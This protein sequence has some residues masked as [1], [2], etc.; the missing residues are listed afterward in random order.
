MKLYN[1]VGLGTFP[2]AGPFGSINEEDSSN[3]LKTYLKG[4]GKYLDVAPT[5][6]FGKVESFLGKELNDIER[7]KF[8]V[9][10]SCG[11]IRNGDGF[12]VSG[13]YQDVIDDCEASLKRLGLNYIDLYISHI[14]DSK[15]PFSETMSAL[16]KL[17]N[18]G[19]IKK[20]GVSNV[21]LEQLQEYNQEGEIEFVQNRFSLLNQAYSNEFIEYITENNIGL[22]AYQAI[23]RGLLTDKMLKD[24]KIDSSDLRAKKP[25]FEK[26][27]VKEISLWVREDLHPI[28]SRNNISITTLAIKWALNNPF[29][30]LCQCGATKVSYLDDFFDV[31]NKDVDD[32]FFDCI[33][34]AYLKFE[35]KIRTTYNKTIR[36][37]MGLESYNLY[38]G[39]ASGK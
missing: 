33:D 32:M 38:S 3:I 39:S 10:T 37:F 31:N 1:G 18:E 7:D 28:A 23:E 13:K 24:F 36:Q 19:K 27:I 26:N 2:F 30:A 35:D 4:G 20:I 34:K 25:E 12:K 11:Y 8:F 22:V 17:K 9:N 14:P 16:R 15:T 6:A 21:N 29:V 5:Y